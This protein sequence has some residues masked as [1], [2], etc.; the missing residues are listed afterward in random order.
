M[1]K[2]KEQKLNEQKAKI[3]SARDS[4][5]NCYGIDCER[6]KAIIQ[7]FPEG[8]LFMKIPEGDI[9][10]TNEV[11]CN[12]LGYSR[13]ELLS[14]NLKDIDIDVIENPEKITQRLFD[15][16]TKGISTFEVR[17][18]RK[19]GKTAY[20]EVNQ[21]YFDADGGFAFCFHKNITELKKNRN[22]DRKKLQRI[23][24]ALKDTKN[25]LS[26]VGNFISDTIAIF[27]EDGKCVDILSDIKDLTYTSK[28]EIIGL[29]IHDIL[30]KDVADARL[31]AIKQAIKTNEV[32]AVEYKL[33]IS[34]G[35][36][37]FEGRIAPL[38]SKGNKKLVIM[39]TRDI[40]EHKRLYE[41]IQESEIMYRTLI[42][43]GAKIGEAIIM[44]QD[45]D[46]R[47]GMHSYVSDQWP[48]ITGYSKSELLGMSFF[49]L[50]SPQY[51]KVS[52][53]RHR[54]RMAGRTIPDLFELSIICKYGKEVPIELTSAVTK[55][56][57]TQ[58]NVVYIRDI[59]ERRQ[60]EL[61]LKQAE[62]SLGLSHAELNQIFKT[63]PDAMCLIDMEFNIL[64]YNNTF[65][66]LFCPGAFEAKGSKCYELIGDNRCN[67][68]SCSL[69]QIA[70]GRDLFLCEIEKTSISGISTPCI[71]TATPFCNQYG[72][73]V[74]IVENIKDITIIKQKE[75]QLSK[76]NTEYLATINM[77]GDIILRLDR[78]NNITLVND[79]ACKFFCL[80]RD[81]ML[82]VK[83]GRHIHPDDVASTHQAFNNMLSTGKPLRGF[84]N[85]QITPL[86]ERFVEWNSYPFY[87]ENGC[88][89]G[90]QSTGRDITER[91]QAEEKIKQ[92]KDHLEE[93]VEKRTIE[94]ED[95]IEQRIRYTKA[96]VH[97]LKTPLTPLLV[98]SDFLKNNIQEE[99]LLSYANN[100][101]RGA[102][103]L[104]RR[105]E[106]LLDLARGEMGILELRIKHF[107][108]TTLLR[109]TIKYVVPEA[110]SNKQSLLT[111][112]PEQLP[113]IYGDEERLRQVL[114]NLL[115]N[116]FKFTQ[117]GGAINIKARAEDS[118]IFVS[119]EDN[120]CGIDKV[121]QKHLFDYYKP[122]YNVTKESSG[123]GLGL[124]LSKIFIELHGGCIWIKS[125]KGKGCNVSFQ[126]P[127]KP[128]C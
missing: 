66:K 23:E 114:F 64:K 103:N 96:L 40:T 10:D 61:N 95:R 49:D 86:G 56:K 123:L 54:S 112:M 20:F 91:K 84:I 62:E 18:R 42:E 31:R 17:H 126:L 69:R 44:L 5:L 125:K 93:L 46:G 73:M 97:E 3:P 33:N 119:I 98:A 6:Y 83:Y 81:E 89:C 76:A 118:S 29:F 41:K 74:G 88:Y 127:L 68:D 55:F 25:R 37:W 106:E 60:M 21:N 72:E 85:R 120:G 87:D 109:E 9:L 115:D 92:Y 102:L 28:E 2:V 71:V 100:I 75:Y 117:R 63:A 80:S 15:I 7:N 50:V 116:A 34:T 77:T 30:P 65:E 45:I 59:R 104:S 79:G 90:R 58:A 32:Q 38:E 4:I 16:K 19:D 82:A 110:S 24:E 113:V 22:N 94:L 57:N 35:V 47:E 124:P 99:P 101:N 27:D 8:F 128:P 36:K 26:T 1:N 105:I 39:T 12:M 11:F 13:D 122:H 53:K 43:L 51:K 67:S 70:N 48:I 111:D 52:I 107:D 121:K 14:M 78:D 108:F